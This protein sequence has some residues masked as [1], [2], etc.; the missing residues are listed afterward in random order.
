[1]YAIFTLDGLDQIVETKAIARREARDLAKL[2]CGKVWAYFIPAG[3]DIE[4][5]ADANPGKRPTRSTG[6]RLGITQGDDW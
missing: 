5:W 4:A 2:G 3:F 6:A 1:M